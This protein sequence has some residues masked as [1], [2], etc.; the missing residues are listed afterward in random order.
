MTESFK[1]QESESTRI[2]VLIS[3]NGSN[4]QA[5]I[6]QIHLSEAAGEIVGV[7]SNVSDAYGLQR[8]KEA[9]IDQLTL[10]HKP[11]TNRADFDNELTR[12]IDR[13]QPDL[14]VLAGFMRIL[15]AD[16]VKHFEGRML[17]I[18]PS[19]LPDYPGLNTHQRV[20]DAKDN[21]HGASVHFVTEELD[22]GPT[23]L[24]ASVPVLEGDDADILA[25]RVH[26][27][28]HQVYPEVVR[29]FCEGRLQLCD[30]VARLDS[31]A[32]PVGGIRISNA[33]AD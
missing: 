33:F 6:D 12:I 21:I 24:Q 14:L 1:K 20:L 10:D 13:F 22:G 5:M 30:G 2:V 29:W 8:A 27:Q 32:L 18:H 3:G 25:Q 31:R 11:F 23:I 7:I 28:E 16:F 19:L 26:V 17:N 15:T 9:G 4:L